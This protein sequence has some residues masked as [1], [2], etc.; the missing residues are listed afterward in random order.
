MVYI[1][2]NT[3][4]VKD[5]LKALGARWDPNARAWMIDSSKAAQAKA[6]VDSAPA[7]ETKRCWECGR[8]VTQSECRRGGGD[9][10]DDNGG[11]GCCYCGC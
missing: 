10:W 5:Q 9:W 7:I 1:T 8:H 6:I 11:A 4:P 2:G 3:Y